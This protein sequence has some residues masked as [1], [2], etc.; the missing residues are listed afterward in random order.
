[1]STLEMSASS[2]RTLRVAGWSLVAVMLAIP[3]LAMQVS[4]EVNWGPE[5]F[6]F[7]AILCASVGGL[8][9]LAARAS[10]NI[11]FRA[12]VFVAGATAFLTIWINM[13]VGIVG[14]SG[15]PANLVYFATVAVGASTMATA[16]G[17]PRRLARAM[18]ATAGLQFLIGV[19]HLV[20][21]VQPAV[22]IDAFFT[23][24]WFIA[25]ALFARAAKQRG[26]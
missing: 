24:T 21:G 9:E 6:L 20:D 25:G 17:D 3:A 5:D 19:V 2:T 13:A 23:L 15:N 26:A 14:E 16:W 18:R 8:F 10:A 11:A 1:M 22:I 4:N 12:A 7:A